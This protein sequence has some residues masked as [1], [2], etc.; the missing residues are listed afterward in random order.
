MRNL[1]FGPYIDIWRAWLGIEFDGKIYNHE[2]LDNECERSVRFRFDIDREVFVRS[3]VLI[4]K[5]LSEYVQTCD[6]NEIQIFSDINGKP[7][8]ENGPQFNV[9]H[10]KLA[11]LIAVAQKGWVGVDAEEVAPIDGL[12]R[13]IRTCCAPIEVSVLFE[14]PYS[15]RLEHFYRIW[16]R[17]EALL[18][19]VGIGLQASLRDIVVLNNGEPGAMVTLPPGPLWNQEWSIFDVDPGPG[20]VAA[21]AATHRLPMRRFSVG[22]PH[23]ETDEGWTTVSLS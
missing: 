4:R 10:S 23:E 2:L 7:F 1:F 14:A 12:E 18:K 11:M 5:I 22:W 15:Q 9:T 17:K 16:T 3:R 8:L 20:F 6:Y 13:L 19:G 21:L